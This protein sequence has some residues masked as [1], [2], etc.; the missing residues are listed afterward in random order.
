MSGTLR[1]LH[2]EDDRSDALPDAAAIAGIVAVRNDY[3]D[4]VRRRVLAAID[5]RHWDIIVSDNCGVDYILNDHMAQ[6]VITLHR[7]LPD[8]TSAPEGS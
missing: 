2:L 3:P 5:G 1:I 8:A 7:L 4:A 6:L